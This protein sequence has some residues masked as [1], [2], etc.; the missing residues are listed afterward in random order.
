MTL[1]R[2]ATGWLDPLHHAMMREWMCH[3]LGRHAL[4]CPAYCLMPDHVHFLWLGWSESSDQ[5]RAIALFREA[6][7]L[8]LL[9]GG[10]ELQ[11]QAYDEVLREAQRD[12]GAFGTVANY[13]FE[14]RFVPDGCRIGGAIFFLVRSYRAIR[15]WIREPKISGSDSGGFTGDWRM[16]PRMMR[17]SDGTVPDET[18]TRS[19]TVVRTAGAVAERVSVSSGECSTRNAHAFR[20]DPATTTRSCA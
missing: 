10:R 7:N 12:R 9:R 16:D 18:L 5:K 14:I 8:E 19:A 4:V 1:E 15:R 11:R 2:R 3:A 17:A 13:I 6:W 20:Y